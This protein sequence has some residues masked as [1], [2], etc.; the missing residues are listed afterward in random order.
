M[1]ALKHGASVKLSFD[2]LELFRYEKLLQVVIFSSAYCVDFA[3]LLERAK[4]K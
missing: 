3:S 1:V 4:R 2:I